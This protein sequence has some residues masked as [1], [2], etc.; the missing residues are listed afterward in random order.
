[1]ILRSRRLRILFFYKTSKIIISTSRIMPIYLF[2]INNE[3]YQL[4]VFTL[5]LKE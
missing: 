4:F 2:L 3:N 1:M 5:K